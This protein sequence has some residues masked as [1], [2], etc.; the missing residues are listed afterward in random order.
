MLISVTNFFRDPDAFKNLENEVIPKLFEGKG[1]G[2]QIRVWS[3]GCATGEEIYS[4][5]ILLHE[6]AT[7]L[8]YLPQIKIF[9][10][11]ISDE[12]LK[13]ARKGWYPQ[14]IAA[15]L[16]EERL[17]NYF[18]VEDAG[19]RVRREI[20]DMVL[21]SK[22]NVIS[23]PPFTNIDLISC[24]NLLIYFNPEL[25]KKVLRLLQYALKTNRYLFL[26]TSESTVGSETFFEPLQNARAI[27]KTKQMVGQGKNPP[28]FLLWQNMRK[29]KGITNKQISA[30]IS[31]EE[32]HKA[33]LADQYGPASIIIN[34]ENE[35]MHFA[36]G[37]NRYL[38]HEEGEP[39]SDL[40]KLVRSE[41]QRTLRSALY[42]FEQSPEPQPVVQQVK[43]QMDGERHL[44]I[45][46][47]QPVIKP[48]FPSGYR[49]VIFEES[50]ETSSEKSDLLDKSVLT[51]SKMVEQLESELDQTKE[52]LQQTI[53]EYETS[54][55][56]L[57]SSNE[58]LQSMNEELQT[59]TEELETSQEELQSVNEERLTRNW[60]IRSKSSSMRM[61]I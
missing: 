48:N 55:E 60:K 49:Q 2:D 14:S 17:K 8:D 27:Y 38:A 10:T 29:L 16:S 37:V 34:E 32:L 12:A 15:D 47:V 46:R 26:G 1:A 4:L 42:R 35:A 22:H 54:N 31:F 40:L 36:R 57:M 43:V 13:T 58:E 24:R 23:D 61:K 30:E 53:E 41:L 18:E 51:E 28:N 50:E 3:I 33:L 9:G 39:T 52:Q 45:I 11:D 44:I 5:A 7:T 59:A 6:Y 25:Q 56:E 21:I 20:R 19:Y